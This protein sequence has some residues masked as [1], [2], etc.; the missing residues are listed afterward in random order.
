MHLLNSIRTESPRFSP[1]GP[2]ATRGWRIPVKLSRKSLLN[3]PL[4]G[5]RIRELG[6]TPAHG[7]KGP[8]TSL[9]PPI[10]SPFGKRGIPGSSNWGPLHPRQEHLLH[11]S[12]HAVP[13]TVGT[14]RGE[15][16]HVWHAP[17]RTWDDSLTHIL[18]LRCHDGHGQ[19]TRG[20]YHQQYGRDG[21]CDIVGQLPRVAVL[22][23]AA[24]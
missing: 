1:E 9:A 21:G 13:A 6:D 2:L 8:C 15:L 7:R 16:Q 5:G 20:Q 18:S 3:P 10:R 14:Q 11:L 24:E 23:R 19:S 17:S 12:S 4:L 22:G